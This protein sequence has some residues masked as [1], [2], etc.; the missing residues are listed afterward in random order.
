MSQSSEEI[1]EHFA[2]AGHSDY[3]GSLNVLAGIFDPVCQLR[4]DSLGHGRVSQIHQDGNRIGRLLVHF[5][6]DGF[7][8]LFE[9]TIKASFIFLEIGKITVEV[10]EQEYRDRSYAPDFDPVALGDQFLRFRRE[11][12]A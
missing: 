9:F 4:L 8:G 6:T 2:D 1:K 10:T 5:L 12:F 3:C 11:R 7:D